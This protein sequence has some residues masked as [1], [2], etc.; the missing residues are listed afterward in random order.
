MSGRV[1][2][3]GSQI[4]TTTMVSSRGVLGGTSSGLL[5]GWL[6]LQGLFLHQGARRGGACYCA[7]GHP[8]SRNR[9]AIM[10]R[11]T[12]ISS[13]GSS[14]SAPEESTDSASTCSATKTPSGG[15][16]ASMCSA[17][18]WKIVSTDSSLIGSNNPTLISRGP[19]SW[20]SPTINP[21]GKNP[22]CR[23]SM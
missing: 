11:R 20:A 16:S 2:V 8:P 18:P 10:F 17:R 9:S 21:G 22:R 3:I 19:R 15:C 12:T 4:V 1:L 14:A 5:K 13:L 23:T 6:A 7:V